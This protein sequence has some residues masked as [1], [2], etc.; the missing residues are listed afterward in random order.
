VVFAAGGVG[1]YDAP[2]DAD[3]SVFEEPEAAWNAK[4]WDAI[5][6]WETKYWVDGPGQPEDRVDPGLRRTVHGWILENYRAEKEEGT[7]QPLDPP[8]NARLRDLRVPLLVMVGTLDE[9]GTQAHCRYLAD[10][11]PGARLETFDGAAHMLNLEQPQRFNALLR[12]FLDE[13]AGR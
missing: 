12:G 11:V 7:P 9:A 3:A 6:N 5:S 13:V 10:A 4:D 2:E 8:A 1:G